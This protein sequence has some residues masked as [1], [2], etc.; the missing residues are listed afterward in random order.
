M[1]IFKKS[2]VLA[3]SLLVITCAEVFAQNDYSPRAIQM[4]NIGAAFQNDEKYELAEKQYKM[5]LTIEPN[6]TEAKNNL[7]TIYGNLAIKEYNKPDYFNAITYARKSLQYKANNA[8]LYMT[9]GNS[10]SKLNRNDDA[11]KAFNKVLIIDSNNIEALQAAAET[12]LLEQQYRSAAP[13]YKKILS[14]NPDDRI[15]KQN[16]K[17][18]ERKLQDNS[19]ASSLNNISSS[20]KAPVSVYNLIKPA[21]GVPA[22]TVSE[23]KVMLDLIWNDSTGKI[24]LN[25]LVKSKISINL[26]TQGA[27]DANATQTKKSN[28][29]YMYGCLPVFTLNRQSVAVNIPYTYIENFNNPNISPYQ[30]IYSLH[31]LVH[32]FCHA[33]RDINFPNLNNSLEEELGASM[34]GLNISYKAITGEYLTKSQ[35]QTYSMQILQSLLCDSHKTLPIY[36]GFQ[37]SMQIK[38][39]IMPYPETYKDIPQMYK[40]LLTEGEIRP[41]TSFFNPT[42]D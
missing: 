3:F 11:L 21:K 2:L 38:G 20:E 1:R 31:A 23:T 10:Y 8:S 34:I 12:Y 15:S 25:N 35:T 22:L 39:I 41:L 5:A 27:F 36:G 28:A 32:E 42:Q 18:I 14:I 7:A 30:R 6:F 16:L 24:L 33:Y 29:L 26:T 9:I 40:E 37:K 4:Y 17:Y 19:L 13:L